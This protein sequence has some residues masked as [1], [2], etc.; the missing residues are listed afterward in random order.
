M[1]RVHIWRCG[2]LVLV[3][4]PGPRTRPRGD[5]AGAGAALELR[6]REKKKRGGG[7]RNAVSVFVFPLRSAVPLFCWPIDYIR[8]FSVFEFGIFHFYFYLTFPF[9]IFHGR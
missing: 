1:F 3:L 6:E 8:K 2:P 4:V 5:G 9:R 7:D